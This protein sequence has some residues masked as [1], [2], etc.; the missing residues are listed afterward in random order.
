[1]GVTAMANETVD[2][3]S[4]SVAD[5]ASSAAKPVGRVLSRG[6]MHTLEKLSV[7]VA[8]VAV[9]LVSSTNQLAS[10]SVALSGQV[11][12]TSERALAD[13]AHVLHGQVA[14]ALATRQW[15]EMDAAVAW[16]L[17]RMSLD[18]QLG[19]ML[20]N[21]CNCGGGPAFTADLATM[22]ERQHIGGIIL[23]GNNYGSFAQT[24]QTLRQMQAHATIPLFVGTDQEGGSVSRV[25]A[26]FGAFPSERDLANSGSL[27][28]AYDAGRHT[29]ADLRQL[30]INIDFAP[31]VDVPVD[32]GGVWGAFRTYSSDPR[33]VVRYAGAF[34]DGLRSAS[35]ISCLKHFPG[36]GSIGQ[37]PHDTLPVVT[38]S[39]SQMRTS[40][41]S[42]YQALIPQLPDMIMATDVL[43]PAVDARY[44]AELSPTWITSILRQQLGYNGVV[45]TDS[46]WMK[47]ITDH[48]SLADAAVQ[49]VVAGDDI[50]LA[51]FDS[52]STQRVLDALRAAVASGR[53]TRT[54]I[55][56]SVRRI[57]TLK[58]K[59]GLLPIPPQVIAANPPIAR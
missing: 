54:R 35:E 40:E 32:G 43:V 10:G 9:L 42:P 23:F 24:Q 44:P 14:A 31:V 55:E 46:M 11:P 2:V 53:L 8:L 12:D 13:Q 48:W 51:A 33:V 22:V 39:L 27:Q 37:D 41:L 16:Y 4:Q 3:Q 26:F 45:I 6:L 29:A 5:N 21:G 47:G 1:M 58:L 59:Y 57:L 56:Q 50:V 36:I 28:V 17:A 49:A 7:V 25:A 19:Q 18:D 20:L 15:R 34:M 38:R 30:G 52:F